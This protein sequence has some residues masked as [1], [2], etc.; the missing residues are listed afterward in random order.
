M[1]IS[2]TDVRVYAGSRISFNVEC[3]NVHRRNDFRFLQEIFMSLYF[4]QVLIP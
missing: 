1:A 2:R 4:S 3:W